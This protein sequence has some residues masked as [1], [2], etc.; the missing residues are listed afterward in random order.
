MISWPESPADEAQSGLSGLSVMIF[1]GFG[2]S[3]ASGKGTIF[4]SAPARADFNSCF[5]FSKGMTFCT[6]KATVPST[7][8]RQAGSLIF[9]PE[10]HRFRATYIF[11]SFDPSGWQVAQP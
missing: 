8:F 3:G 9:L 6:E 2:F 11:L 7:V 1:R 10:H 4:R 5:H